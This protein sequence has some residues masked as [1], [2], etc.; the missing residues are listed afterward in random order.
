M[1]KKMKN[2]IATKRM[3]ITTWQHPISTDYLVLKV[4]DF[5]PTD[6]E[7]YWDYEVAS[8]MI[9]KSNV[10]ELRDVLN[11]LI[12]KLTKPSKKKRIKIQNEKNRE[13]WK[14]I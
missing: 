11:E 8:V 12:P 5:A 2:I 14:N 6:K 3:R 13:S 4:E 7:N 10:I 9:E 1:N